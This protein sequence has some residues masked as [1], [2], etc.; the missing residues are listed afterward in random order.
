MRVFV[1]WATD[2]GLVSKTFATALHKW[3]RKVIQALEP[4]LSSDDLTPGKRWG[5]EIQK[6]LNETA[7]GIFCLTKDGQRSQWQNFEAGAL[8]K[9][10]KDDNYVIPILVEMR[11]SDLEGPLIAFQALSTS[12][13]DM[14]N[15]VSTVNKALNDSSG[16]RS[17]ELDLLQESFNGAWD[18]LEKVIAGLPD[19][20]RGVQPPAEDSTDDPAF[21]KLVD[22]YDEMIKLARDTNNV[23]NQLMMPSG[24]GAIRRRLA[25]NPTPTTLSLHDIFRPETRVVSFSLSEDGKDADIDTFLNMLNFRGELEPND[26]EVIKAA[27]G[28][29]SLGY[30]VSFVGGRTPTLQT[31]EQ[32]AGATGFSI[33]SVRA[34]SD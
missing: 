4:W 13:E 8:A 28:G 33:H 14:F 29:N 17:L 7:V 23:V 32:A 30:N 24:I 22:T 25:V 27:F 20:P 19:L 10:V 16:N 6:Q 11:T 18:E 26:I 1:S 5:N 2:D 3:L 34:M 15:L 21:S 9:S 12:R 31:I